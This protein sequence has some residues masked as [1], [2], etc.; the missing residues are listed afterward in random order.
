MPFE[1]SSNFIRKGKL[2]KKKYYN[3]TVKFSEGGLQNSFSYSPITDVGR[4]DVYQKRL[5]TFLQ[6]QGCVHPE[7]CTYAAHGTTAKETW[8]GDT[9]RH[10][11]AEQNDRRKRIL[12]SHRI[13]VKL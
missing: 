8:T 3:L 12:L 2:K 1:L 4:K 9:Q 10:Q 13:R 11:Q 5:C 6:L 7:L